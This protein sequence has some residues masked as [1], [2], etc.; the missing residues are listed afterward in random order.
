MTIDNEGQRDRMLLLPIGNGSPAPSPGGVMPR[1][2]RPPSLADQ[3]RRAIAG[4]GM[5][6][7]QLAKTT[8]VHQAQLSRFM[9]AERSLTLTAVDRLCA[10]LELRLVGPGLDRKGD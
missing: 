3:L 9:R 1:R 2:S 5:S 4:C 10:H 6:L 7:N 8:G